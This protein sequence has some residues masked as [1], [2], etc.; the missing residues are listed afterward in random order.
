M[1]PFLRLARVLLAARRQ[2]PMDTLDESV[3]RFRVLPQDLDYAMHLN[4]G[5]YLTLMDLGRFD[6]IVR[7]GLLGPLLKRR[8]LPVVA[9]STIRHRRS[10]EPFQTYELRTRIVGWDEKG[11][12]I[13]QQFVREGDVHALG[14]I[15]GV[16]R[17]GPRTVAPA[18]VL[19]L[20][21]KDATSPPLPT[22]IEAWAASM[23]AQREGR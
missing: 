10:L 18:D 9:S 12:Y 7:G 16:F 23:D 20:A 22:W 17:D 4:N 8:W 6:L 2:T 1:Y 14:A 15:K 5:R 21:G 13:E 19:A 3:V 11:F